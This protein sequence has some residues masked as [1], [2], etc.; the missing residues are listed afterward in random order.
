MRRG[1]AALAA[2]VLLASVTA[3]AAQG[4][5]VRAEAVP[6]SAAPSPIQ[7]IVIIYQENHSFDDVL[8]D[9]C[10]H[11]ATRCNGSTRDVTTADG[12]VITNRVMPDIVPTAAHS[13]RAQ[14]FGMANK[15]NR[16][17]SRPPYRCVEHI[18]EGNIPNLA[19]LANKFTVSDATYA[20]NPAQSFGAHVTLAAGTLDRFQG[21]IPVPSITG[22]K[23]RAGW[24]CPSHLDALW[25]R[26]PNFRYVPSCVP[27][28][29]G[30]GPYRASPV[31]YVDTIMQTL[32]AAGLSWHV[33]QG[34]LRNQP[35]NGGWSVCTYF[36]W[37]AAHRFDLQHNSATRDFVRAAG[38]GTLPNL[39]IL[40]AAS[41]YGQHNG[42]SMTI[43]DN[44]I[45]NMVGAA[46]R[47]PDWGSTAV[48]VTYDDCG[49][50]YD[51]V[52]PPPGLGLRNPMVIVSPWAKRGSTD[53]TT[54][55]QP[56][57]MLAFV[58]HTFGLTSLSRQVNQA[59][60]YSNSFDFAQKPLS[61]VP[62]THGHIS[63]TERGILNALPDTDDDPT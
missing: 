10:E 34:D 9:L 5:G 59:Y 55:T 22:A 29:H 25:G 20:S 42:N 7:H 23:P 26:D 15:W 44:Y 6:A 8:G 12:T 19:R 47:G 32:E 31:P 4:G 60:D 46:M 11:R 14:L 1:P 51:H 39:S 36:N 28:I 57:S 18:P 27:D 45:G 61:G 16:V 35:F 52:K 56:Y 2:A 17:C 62:M 48:F 37:C 49:C 33:Y 40:M 58:Q 24:G 43:G 38:A 41:P 3:A 53:H 13:R 30:R 21:D 63:A 50:F 54:A